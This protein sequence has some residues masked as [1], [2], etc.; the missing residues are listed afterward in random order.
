MT[1]RIRI[2]TNVLKLI[3]SIWTPLKILLCTTTRRWLPAPFWNK[4]LES[5]L[6][7]ERGA[8]H[9]SATK[10]E[11][12]RCGRSDKHDWRRHCLGERQRI[13]RR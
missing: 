9:K 7:L 2:Q 1:K 5:L 13:A 12:L 4:L 6:C 11:H 8:S 10:A 3:G